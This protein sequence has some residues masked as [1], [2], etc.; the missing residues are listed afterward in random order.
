M[1]AS[2]S[3]TRLTEE[4]S[5]LL[6][7]RD[8]E[9]AEEFLAS[10]LGSSPELDAVVHWQLGR[11][12]HFWNKASSAINHLNRAVELSASA[13]NELLTIQVLSD[14]KAARV[15]QAKQKP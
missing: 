5:I 10:Q 15:E 2:V 1:D 6:A 4:V 7:D 9:G 12:Y 11:V 14:L 3:L 13:K 8:F